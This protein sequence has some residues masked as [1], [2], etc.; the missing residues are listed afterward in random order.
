MEVSPYFLMRWIALEMKPD[1]LTVPVI[2]LVFMT[3]FIL[4]MQEL[5]VY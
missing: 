5:N 4:K 1:S 2:Q 3:V